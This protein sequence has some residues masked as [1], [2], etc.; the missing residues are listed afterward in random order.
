MKCPSCNYVSHDY[1]DACPSCDDNWAVF[2][3]EIGLYARP[4]GTVLDLSEVAADRTQ[5]AAAEFTT[6][7]FAS[8]IE[9]GAP[10]AMPTLEFVE[11]ED[12]EPG[13]G[14]GP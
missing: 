13:G 4:S 5:P 9:T 1:L 12:E 10:E 7:P 14:T 2:K 8:G 6:A 11:I 3:A